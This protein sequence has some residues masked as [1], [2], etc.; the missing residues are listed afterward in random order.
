MDIDEML[1]KLEKGDKW[2]KSKGID[3]TQSRFTDIVNLTR[4][5]LDHQKRNDIQ[6]LLNAN[7]NEQLRYVFA[8]IEGFAFAEIYEAFKEEKNHICISPNWRK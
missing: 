8:L 2:L 6:R 4:V 7:Y 1:S 5:I 3:T